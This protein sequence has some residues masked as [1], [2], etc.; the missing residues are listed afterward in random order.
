[1]KLLAYAKLNEMSK[2]GAASHAIKCFIDNLPPDQKI[3]VINA[4][5]EIKLRSKNTY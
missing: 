2:A 3:R 4:A 1:M 5:K